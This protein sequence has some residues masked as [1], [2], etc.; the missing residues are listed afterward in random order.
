MV[1]KSNK[2]TQTPRK[3]PRKRTQ[4]PHKRPRKRTQTPRKR[5][6]TKKLG[7]LPSIFIPHM[8]PPPP[9]KGSITRQPRLVVDVGDIKG[10]DTNNEGN[11][12]FK[13]KYPV[14]ITSDGNIVANINGIVKEIPKVPEGSIKSQ[15]WIKEFSDDYNNV[16]P[17][18]QQAENLI[19]KDLALTNEE[20]KEIKEK[21]TEAIKKKENPIPIFKR[22]LNKIYE[23]K[24]KIILTSGFLA[25]LMFLKYN[26]PNILT[27]FPT[28]Y[29]DFLESLNTEPLRLFKIRAKSLL[30]KWFTDNSAALVIRTLP[31]EI[32][33]SFRPGQT[34]TP[35]EMWFPHALESISFLS[36]KELVK[37]IPRSEVASLLSNAELVKQLPKKALNNLAEYLGYSS[38]HPAGLV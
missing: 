37:Q 12:V 8:P 34:I 27:E 30:A 20:N 31:G 4:T 35:G 28:L 25:G 21:V 38:F 7:L 1:R 2:R 36:N 11:L 15:G 10:I 9:L 33:P 22:V 5:R 17:G 29:K 16:I 6:Q 19:K 18:S 32:N 26:F 13:D 3:R 23:H 14:K 24:G